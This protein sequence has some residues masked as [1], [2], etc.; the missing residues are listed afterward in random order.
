[1]HALVA[2]VKARRAALHKSKRIGGI[3]LGEKGR[4]VLVELEKEAREDDEKPW[5]RR[6][7]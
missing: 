3:L 7:G 4:E 1:M 6:W 5:Y 2:E